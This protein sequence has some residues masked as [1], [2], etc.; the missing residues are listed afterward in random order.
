[1]AEVHIHLAENIRFARQNAG[2]TQWDLAEVCGVSPT[3]IANYES[4]LRQPDLV[5]L[6][7]IAEHYHLTL[8]ALVL[9][10]LH[11]S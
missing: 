7:R 4:G 5:T 6:A 3:A 10:K 8:D 11:K 2:E 1:M 9:G